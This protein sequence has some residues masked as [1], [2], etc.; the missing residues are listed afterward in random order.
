LA[1]VPIS[2]HIVRRIAETLTPHHPPAEPFNC[3][4]LREGRILQHSACPPARRAYAGRARQS[5]VVKEDSPPTSNQRPGCRSARAYASAP[6]LALC[7]SQLV[8]C[9]N[10]CRVPCYVVRYGLAFFSWGTHS[11]VPLLSVR[12]PNLSYLAPCL[13]A[14]WLARSRG[15][16]VSRCV[17]ICDPLLRYADRAMEYRR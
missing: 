15:K 16:P 9:M 14:G 1:V 8:H 17:N 10:C 7:S 2:H 12:I 5:P 3:A 11:T 13:R 4:S 6:D